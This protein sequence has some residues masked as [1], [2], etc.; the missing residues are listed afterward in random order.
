MRVGEPGGSLVVQVGQGTGL[1]GFFRCGVFRQDAIGIT[2]HD[3]LLAADQIG[4]VEPSVAKPV[5]LARRRDDGNS[6]PVVFVFRS[7]PLDFV[8]PEVW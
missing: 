6:L 2:R 7:P 8:E 4:W 3:L 1:E 5:K